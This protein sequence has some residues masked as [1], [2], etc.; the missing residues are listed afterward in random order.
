MCMSCAHVLALVSEAKMPRMMPAGGQTGG[1]RVEEREK[2]RGNI[3][4]DD[5]SAK[6]RGAHSLHA[7][8]VSPLQ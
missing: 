6:A 2:R 5:S 4:P 7:L 8:L 3:P 1:G